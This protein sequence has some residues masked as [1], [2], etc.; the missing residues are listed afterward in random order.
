MFTN[1]WNLHHGV[2]FFFI[3]YLLVKVRVANSGEEDFIEVETDGLTYT[4]LLKAICGEL[5]VPVNDVV[6]I[7][8]LPNVL[9]R[10]DKDVAR[11]IQGQ[12]LEVVLKPGA[13]YQ[14]LVPTY[15]GFNNFVGQPM[16]TFVS[17]ASTIPLPSINTTM[18]TEGQSILGTSA[19]N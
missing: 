4:G 11:L 5:E 9:I 17:T 6:K 19:H 2:L 3:D 10:K 13:V 12:E 8:K 18:I 15:S 16:N 7:R 14:P 1:S